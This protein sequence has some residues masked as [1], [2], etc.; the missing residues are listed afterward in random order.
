M[1]CNACKIITDLK[2]NT[3]GKTQQCCWWQLLCQFLPSS[4]ETPVNS[5]CS[6]RQW[7]AEPVWACE[8]TDPAVADCCEVVARRKFH[9][10]WH[11]RVWCRTETERCTS[12]PDTTQ[13]RTTSAA[14][15]LLAC[16]HNSTETFFRSLLSDWSQVI[17]LSSTTYILQIKLP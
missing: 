9:W 13:R 3:V 6:R 4:L 11:R 12:V 15:A 17:P 1:S 2:A 7:L 14:T 10:T 16:V 5:S 8:E